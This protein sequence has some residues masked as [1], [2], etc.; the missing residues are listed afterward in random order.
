MID[1]LDDVDAAILEVLAVDGRIANNALAERVGVAPS[2]CLARVRALRE[3]GVVRGFAA[4]IDPAALG[5]P[6]QAIIA[7]VMASHARDRLMAFMDEARQMPEV[8]NVYLLGGEEDFFL[9]VAAPTV[10][11]LHEVVIGRLS[12]HPDVASTRTSLV[13]KYARSGRVPLSATR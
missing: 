9:H 5:H 1:G 8:L 12:G 10:E 13:F 4:D 3:R 11:N 7:V 2:T 6:I